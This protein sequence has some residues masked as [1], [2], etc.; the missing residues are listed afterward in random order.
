MGKRRVSVS[1]RVYPQSSRD[2]I[3]LAIKIKGRGSEELEGKSRKKAPKRRQ[4]ILGFISRYGSLT[5]L[6]NVLRGSMN[7]AAN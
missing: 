1:V 3:Y 4:K 5:H 6:F 2:L 7:S